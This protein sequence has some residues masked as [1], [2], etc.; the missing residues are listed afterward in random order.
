LMDLNQ[1]LLSGLFVSTTEI[2]RMCAT[3]REAGALGAKL[4]GAGGGG[5]VIAL[6][7]TVSA[8]D[9]ILAAWKADGFSGFLASVVPD[10]RARELENGRAP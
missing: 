4:T 7:P 8:S 2:E 5:S 1:M 9:A 6:A 10:P 3:A